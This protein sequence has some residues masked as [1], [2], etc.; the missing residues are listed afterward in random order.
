MTDPKNAPRQLETDRGTIQREDV[1]R[2]KIAY[3]GIKVKSPVQAIRAHC[4]SCCSGRP[5]E[6]R[7]CTITRCDLYLFRFGTN[8]SLKGKRRANSHSFS[9]KA[10]SVSDLTTKKLGAVD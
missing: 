10:A 7:L 1:D 6:V 2:D 3:S 9:K 5:K 8:P 4:L